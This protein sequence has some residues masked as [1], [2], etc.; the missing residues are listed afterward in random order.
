MYFI[1]THTHLF[2]DAFDGDRDVAVQRAIDSGVELMLLPNVD[3]ETIVPMHNLCNTFPKN[4]FPMMGL[5]PGSVNERWE[6]DLETVRKHLFEGDTY[7]AVGEIGMDLYWDKTFIEQ[8][9]IVFRRQIQ[10]A[11]QLGLPVVIHAREAFDEIFSI[12]DE[13]NGP[14][15]R[16]VFHCF[17][18][19]EEQARHILNYGGFKLG[20]GG[21][22][23]YKK[24]GLD[25]VLSQLTLEDLVLETDAPYLPPVPHRGKRNESGFLLHVA[26]KVAEIFG[27]STEKVAEITSSNAFEVF[28]KIPSINEVHQTLKES[29]LPKGDLN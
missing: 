19:N 26:N 10:W 9:R 2:L 13:L 6:E 16:G 25:E 24:A 29:D 27:V 5:H 21:V 23:T 22:V 8:Q 12:V 11:K 18:G 4:C 14:E 17:T 1:D 15:L 7:I 28:D 20:I 3:I